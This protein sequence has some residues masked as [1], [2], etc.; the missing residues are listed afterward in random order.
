MAR[1][2]HSVSL[3][4]AQSAWLDENP[5]V[6]LSQIAQI[7]VDRHKE[8]QETSGYFKQNKELYQRIEKIMEVVQRQRDFMEKHGLIEEFIKSE[9]KGGDNETYKR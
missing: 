2:I 5:E 7:G 1:K 9:L 8:I 3:S 6:S 4:E